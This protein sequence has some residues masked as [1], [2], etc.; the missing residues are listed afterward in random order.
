MSMSLFALLQTGCL[1]AF[2]LLFLGSIIGHAIGGAAEFNEDQQLHGGTT[3]S[4]LHFLTTSQFWFQSF[5]N[6]KS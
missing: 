2:A 6:W 4:V 5:Q 1:I 3:M